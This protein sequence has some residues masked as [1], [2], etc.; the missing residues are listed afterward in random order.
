MFTPGVRDRLGAILCGQG[1]QASARPGPGNFRREGACLEGDFDAGPV[2]LG[3]DSET[4]E[5]TL[6][7]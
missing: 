3:H 2:A 1:E 4:V 6:L 7:G 5:G